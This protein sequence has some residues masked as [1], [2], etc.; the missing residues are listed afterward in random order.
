MQRQCDRMLEA[1][2]AGRDAMREVIKDFSSSASVSQAEWE[3][4][5]HLNASLARDAHDLLNLVLVETSVSDD[6]LANVRNLTTFFQAA[7]RLL[8][9]MVETVGVEAG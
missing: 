7:E 1:L 6:A 9:T 3:E 8:N 5:F 2:T 4:V